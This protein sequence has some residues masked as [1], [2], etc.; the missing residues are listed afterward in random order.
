MMYL[1]SIYDSCFVI[2]IF[3]DVQVPSTGLVIAASVYP[4]NESV[5]LVFSFCVGNEDGAAVTILDIQYAT[6]Q[7]SSI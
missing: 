5:F 1:F 7:R 4:S 3:F 6:I 2:G